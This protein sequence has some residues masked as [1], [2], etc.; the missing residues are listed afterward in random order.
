MSLKLTHSNPS[1]TKL[2][3]LRVRHSPKGI[4]ISRYEI[5]SGRPCRQ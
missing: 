3:E 5:D 2:L 4:R 1:R